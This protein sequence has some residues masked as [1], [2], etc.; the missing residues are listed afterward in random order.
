MTIK[1]GGEHLILCTPSPPVQIV[2]GWTSSVCTHDHKKSYG[3]SLQV[4]LKLFNHLKML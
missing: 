4:H 2:E 1:R 3:F